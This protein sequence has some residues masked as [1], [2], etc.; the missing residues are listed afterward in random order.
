M[1]FNATFN[2]ISIWL[3]EKILEETTNLQQDIDKLRDESFPLIG[4]FSFFWATYLRNNSTVF[5]E[6]EVSIVDLTVGNAVLLATR[7]RAS[8]T[9][10][11]DSQIHNWHRQLFKYSTVFPILMKFS[12]HVHTS[13]KIY[14]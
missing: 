2:N 12:Q 13:L 7:S 8:K 14:K 9:D 1:V 10:I 4:R 11:C 6:L 5:E 3:M